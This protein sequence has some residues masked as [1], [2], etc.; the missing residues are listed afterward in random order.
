MRTGTWLLLPVLLATPIWSPPAAG[1]S[2]PEPITVTHVGW[3]ADRFVPSRTMLALWLSRAPDGGERIAVVAGNLD[4]S[5]LLDRRGNMVSYRPDA[6]RLPAG[7]SDVTIY[8]V[9][10]TG[11]WNEIGRHPLKVQAAMGLDRAGATPVVDLSSAG[12]LGRGTPVPSTDRATYQDLT[13]RLGLDAS[14]TGRGYSLTARANLQGVSNETQRLRWGTAGR[15]A[16]AVDLADYALGASF[17]GVEVAFGGVTVGSNRHLLNGFGARGLRSGIQL[18]PAA[19]L[20]VGLVSGTSM[21][22]WSN[23]TGLTDADHRIGLASLSLQFLPSRPGGLQ[24]DITAMDGAVRPA[25]GFNQGA[26]T[27]AETSRGVGVTVMASDVRQRIRFAGGVSRSRFTNPADPLLFGDTTVVAV[28]P[29]TRE[30]RF[31]ELTLRLLDGLR[32]GA[33]LPVSLGVTGRHE[34]VDPLYRSVGAFLAADQENNALELAGSA[35]ALSL[36]GGL[37][38]TRDNLGEIA[39]I[40]TTRTRGLTWSASVPLNALVG[41]TPRP[42]WPAA[43]FGWQRTRQFGDGVPVDGDFQPTHIPDQVSINRSAALAWN[44]GAVSAGYR[45]NRSTQDNRQVGRERADFRTDVHGISLGAPASRALTLGVDAALERNRSDEL[46]L[47]QRVE[48]VGANLQW[49]LAL[50]TTLSGAVSQMWSEDPRSDQ[51][52]RNTE[53]YAELAQGFNLYRRPDGGTQG[54]VF[55][56]YTRTRLASASISLRDP[57]QPALTW[58][59]TAGSSFRAF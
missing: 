54:R 8:L 35:G 59:V 38:A 40:L 37:S 12:M 5:A 26:A 13:A 4:L 19:R 14:G 39:S 32:A 31:A 6:V 55:V 29:E 50:R 30:A 25:A 18:G 53:T 10:T 9:D 33:N 24:L 52:I 44:I 45:W 7:E 51:R 42:F 57:F 47:T 22:G 43:S 48:R 58:S 11:A 46:E 1:Q 36:Q 16:P 28:R 20:D 17:G 2:A 49:Q 21:V 23:V 15:D 3:P 56:R 34:R 27:D 41:A